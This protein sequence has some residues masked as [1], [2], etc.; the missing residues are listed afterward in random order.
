MRGCGWFVIGLVAILGLTTACD[1]VFLRS[2]ADGCNGACA[3]AGGTCDANDECQLTCA[4]DPCTCPP[5]HDCQIEVR[6][7]VPRIDCTAATSCKIRC[8]ADTNDEGYCRDTEIACGAGGC[9]VNCT[10][11]PFSCTHLRLFCGTGSCSLT[12]AGLGSCQENAAVDCGSSEACTT[13]CNRES[14]TSLAVSCADAAACTATC[15]PDGNNTCNRASFMC[16][17][18]ASCDLDCAGRP[19]CTVN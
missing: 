9:D 14:C 4:A 2:S 19:G 5:G 10:L 7:A 16:Q 6:G 17:R 18:A 13:S 15:D 3:A 11:E 12:C 8:L 1:L